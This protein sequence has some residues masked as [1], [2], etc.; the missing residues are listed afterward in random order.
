MLR[1]PLPPLAAG[2][3]VLLLPSITAAQE[4]G[5]PS[6]SGDPLDRGPGQYLAWWKILLCWLIF[7][8]W[9]RTTDW[10]NRD[11]HEIGESIEM[12]PGLWNPIMVFTFLIAFVFAALTIPVFAAGYLVL[13]AAYV[14]PL[15]TYILQ[16]NGRVTDDQKVLTPRHIKDWFSNLGKGGRRKKVEPQAAWEQGPAIDLSALG[17]EEQENQANLITARQSPG[18]VT[19]KELIFD[20]MEKHADKIMLDYTRDAVGVRYEIDGFWHN[21]PNRDRE[22]GDVMLAVMKKLANLN[23]AERRARQEGNF[24]VAQ[25]KTKYTIHLVSQG[26][27][28]GERAILEFRGKSDTYK[29]LEELGMREKMREQ[30]KELMARDHGLILISS[31][32]SDGLTTTCTVALKSTDRYLRDF[33]G[34]YDSAK[35]PRPYVENVE[36]YSYNSEAGETPD[37]VLPKILLKQPDAVVVPELPNA[38]TVDILCHQVNEEN[39]LVIGTVRAK[40]AVESLLRIMMLKVQPETFANAVTC[41]LNQRLVRRLC[42][43]CKQPYEPSPDLLKKLGIPPGRISALYREYQPPPPGQQT[44]GQPEI[45]PVCSGIGYRGRAAIYELLVVDDKIRHALAHQPRLETLRPLAAQSGHRTLQEEGV[46]LVAQGT[47]SLKELQ[48]VLKK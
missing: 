47:T 24:G 46:L 5:W 21:V 13:V 4:S 9:V 26:T 23:M 20:A 16:R 30:F 12:P 34:V 39:K 41:V 32:P 27:K 15:A 3:L 18:Y 1:F 42:D 14:G 37:V 11:T 29:S 43:S 33:A 48:R 6:Y 17:A 8:S 44:K 28:T 2:L 45:C 19:V 38:K 35:P 31:L 40:E 36:V 10:V 25:Q 7:I 22:S